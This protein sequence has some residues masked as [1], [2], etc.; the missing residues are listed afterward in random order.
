MNN[1]CIF[2]TAFLFIVFVYPARGAPLP[3]GLDKIAEYA[4]TWKTETGHFDTLFS[5]AGR[6]SATI[7][8]DCWRSGDY[9]ACDQ[10]LNGKSKALLIY[11]YDA[12]DDTYTVYPITAGEDDVQTGKLIIHGNVWTFPWETKEKGKIVYFR[13]TNIFTA[14][15]T[16][17]YRE[18]YSLDKAH[19]YPMAQGYER[20]LP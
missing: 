6:D 11:T 4:G 1:A 17:E 13:V 9:Y 5:K 19:W 15:D 3:A 20:K 2:A 7:K 18:E 10:Y 14:L 16:I 8:N 12:K